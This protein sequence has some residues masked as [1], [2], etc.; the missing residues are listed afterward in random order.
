MIFLKDTHIVP[1]V[2]IGIYWQ[3][4]EKEN[5]KKTKNKTRLLHTDVWFQVHV[6]I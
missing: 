5:Y 2:Y 1:M 3:H 6:S 4:K